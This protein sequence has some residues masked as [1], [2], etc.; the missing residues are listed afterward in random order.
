[1]HVDTFL[2][3]FGI[4]A[5]VGLILPIWLGGIASASSTHG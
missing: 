3:A 2:L 4:F 1:M 5:V